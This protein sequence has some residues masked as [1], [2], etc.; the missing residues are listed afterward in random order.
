MNNPLLEQYELPPFDK[1]KPEHILPAVDEILAGNRKKIEALLDSEELDYDSLVLKIEALDDILNQAFSPVSHMNSVVNSSELR[2]AYN[3]CLPK[4]TQ[5][6]T[7]MGQNPRLYEAYQAIVESD[8]FQTLDQAKKMV[9]QH[10]IRDFKLSGINLLTEEQQKFSEIS[11]RLSELSSQFRDNVLD[12]T[13]A[14][15]RQFDNASELS[16]LPESALQLAMQTAEQRGESGYVFTLEFPS[17]LPVMTYCEN[18]AFRQEIYEAFVTRASD[19][20]PNA[21]KWDNSAVMHEI[22][23]LRKDMSVLLG[24]SNYAEY[25]IAKKMAKS[26]DQVLE[27]LEDLASKSKEVASA[28]YDELCEFAR[29]EYGQIELNAWDLTFYADKY[30]EQK[31]DISEEALRPYFPAPRVL[32][33]MFEVVRRL[34]DIEV[35]R[36]NDVV[37]WHADV[38]TFDIRKSGTTI[39]RFYL[40]LFARPNKQ[41]GA[42]MDE[43][44][45]RR[46]LPK[47][48]EQVDAIQ[49]PVAYL[50]CNFTGP[51][52]DTP[53]LLT[54][55][56]VVTLFH[57]FGHGLHH[58]LTK[59]TAAGVSGING[60]AWDAVELPSQFMENWCWQSEAL[61]FISGHYESEDVLPDDMLAKMLAGKNFQSAMVM[62]RQLEFALF[63]FKLHLEFDPEQDG[64]VQNILDDVR[65][66]VAV[67]QA[68]AFNKFQ[69][70]FSHIFGG[71]YAAGYYSYKWAEV[72][73]ADAFSRFE[74]DGIFNRQTGEQFLVSVLE[75]GGSV[76]PMEMFV[77]FMGREPQVE[78]LLKQDGIV[79]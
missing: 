40:D 1:I 14:W 44:R 74:Q 79:A 17:Y 15:S 41:G 32:D 29:K 59:V 54:H 28:Q 31:F 10:A 52:G 43:C 45:V 9:L 55:D 65:R 2:E 42:W 3:A 5:Y 47:Q 72:L 67:V 78:A 20:G 11:Q 30:K 16:G 66:Q 68:P 34:Y 25:S 49:L 8:E 38:Q 27:F 75:Q 61:G 46:A 71:G 4:I 36:T 64:Q 60:V 6:A 39:A 24:F 22:L 23:T 77:S 21:G 37:S 48:S 33:G 51:I 13:M 19:I 12:A 73:S 53:S 76:E 7:E 69:H 26:T 70:G 63:D 57:E 50:T 58:M 56:E 18:E 62:V 35:V